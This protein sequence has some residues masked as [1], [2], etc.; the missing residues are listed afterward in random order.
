M[1]PDGNT[2]VSG[3]TEK[4][5]RVW[6]TR[7]Y[8]KTMKL[9]GHSDNVKALILN[10]DGTQCLS[11]SSDGTI[12]L[13][14]LGQQQCIQTIRCHTQGVWALAVRRHQTDQY[15]YRK[16]IIHICRILM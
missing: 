10:W 9:K 14:N 6:D 5:L 11:G 16:F 2:L 4:V 1:S 8:I 13:W 12:K 15:W 7:R 3:S